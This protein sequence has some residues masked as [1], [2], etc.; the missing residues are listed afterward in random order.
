V[1]RCVRV[2][3]GPPGGGGG[4][5]SCQPALISSSAPGVCVCVCA[6]EPGV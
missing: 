4:V 6:R 3:A 5:G 2:A 1:G